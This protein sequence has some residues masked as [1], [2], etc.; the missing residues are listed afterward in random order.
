MILVLQTLLLLVGVVAKMMTMTVAD[1]TYNPA[2]DLQLYVQQVGVVA[3]MMTMTVADLTYNPAN[4][5]Q[6]PLYQKDDL[7]YNPAND[8]QAHHPGP[9]LGLEVQG[10]VD[11]QQVYRANNLPNRLPPVEHV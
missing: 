2:N 3:K 11:G 10:L 6:F 5:H 9:R 4:D 1:L 7:T 8:H